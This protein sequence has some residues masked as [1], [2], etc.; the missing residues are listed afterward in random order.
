MKNDE[1]VFLDIRLLKRWRDAGHKSIHSYPEWIEYVQGKHNWC[2]I[3]GRKKRVFFDYDM[4]KFL[5]DMEER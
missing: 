4:E 5:K 1:T 2:Y 3:E